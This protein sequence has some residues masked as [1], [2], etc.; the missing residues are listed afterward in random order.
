[1]RYIKVCN[2]D[3]VYRQNFSS[4]EINIRSIVRDIGPQISS[5]FNYKDVL[6]TINTI[7]LIDTLSSPVFLQNAIV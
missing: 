4:H 1:M 6:N 7:K 5:H 3:S 2:T